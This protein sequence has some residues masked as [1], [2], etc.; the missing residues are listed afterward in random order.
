MIYSEG[1][2]DLKVGAI[3]RAAKLINYTCDGPVTE[4]VLISRALKAVE[5]KQCSAEAMAEALFESLCE[6]WNQK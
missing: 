1:M 2:K 5:E 3:E 4:F 6:T